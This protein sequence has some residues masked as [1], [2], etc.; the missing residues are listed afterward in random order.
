MA[1]GQPRS[2]AGRLAVEAGYTPGT[3]AYYTYTRNITRYTTTTG[4]QRRHA[5]AESPTLAKLSP[6]AQAKVLQRQ[7]VADAGRPPVGQRVTM[8]A[9]IKVGNDQAESRRASTVRTVT[10]S[11]PLTAETAALLRDDPRAFWNLD[12]GFGSDV[13]DADGYGIEA[14]TIVSIGYR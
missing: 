4:T 12:F 13:D 9:M 10:S 1:K 8:K 7:A 14:L 5:K 11:R 6:A 2:E 3:R